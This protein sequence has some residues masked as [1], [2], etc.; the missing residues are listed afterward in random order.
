MTNFPD[1]EIMAGKRISDRDEDGEYI[2]VRV[3]ELVGCRLRAEVIH[4]PAFV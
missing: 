4:S 1:E 2:T 3:A